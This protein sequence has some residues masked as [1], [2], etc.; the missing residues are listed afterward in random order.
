MTRQGREI[1]YVDSGE[2]KILALVDGFVKTLR[3]KINMYLVQYNTSN[4]I[5]VLQKIVDN[6]NNTFHSG[7]KKNTSR[8]N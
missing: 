2:H 3:Q 5:D 1:N 8:S 6:Y 7:I 4:Y